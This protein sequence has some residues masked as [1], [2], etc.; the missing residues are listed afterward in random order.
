VMDSPGVEYDA[1]KFLWLGSAVETQ[2]AFAHRS[3]GAKTPEELLGAGSEIVIGGLSP[4]NPKDMAMRT[5]FNLLGVRYKYVNGYPGNNDA[6]AAM[7]RGEINFFE[8]SMTGWATG[9]VPLANEGT[10]YNMVQRGIARGGSIV[11][12]PRLPDLPTY[13]EAVLSLKGEASRTTVEFR[14]LELLVKLASMQR[15]VVYPPGVAPE[16]VET[17]RKAVADSFADEDFQ[18]T[19]EKQF[20]FRVESVTGAQAQEQI[21]DVIRRASEDRAALE[22]LQTL[23]K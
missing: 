16:L 7:L 8:E 10:A 3:L 18:A 5:F 15:E 4:D 2:V 22:Y 20:G 1:N 19:A 23:A 13:Q 17:M 11:R 6:R 21:A 12:D 9:I 14:A